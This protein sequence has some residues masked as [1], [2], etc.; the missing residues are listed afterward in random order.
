MVVMKQAGVLMPLASLPS[1][2]GVGDMGPA[3][4]A[5][6]D[7]LAQM[8]M[9]VWQVLP[10]NPLGYGN[11]PYQPYSSFAGD[12]IYLSPEL[13]LKDG[14][15]TATDL[16][17]LNASATRIDYPA[18]RAYKEQ[19]LHQAFIN[20]SRKS[21][22]NASLAEFKASTPWLAD[23]ALFMALKETNHMQPW[24][25]WPHEHKHALS[26]DAAALRT[27]LA[28]LI[29]YHEF[30]QF[31][32]FR[33]WQALKS[34]ANQHNIRIMGDIPIYLG[35]DS[36]DVWAN[37]ELF[38]LDPDGNPRVVAGVPPD[39]FSSTGQRWGN[40]IY[41]WKQLA[42]TGFEFW[43]KRLE[44]NQAAYDIIRIDHFRAFDTYWQIPSQCPTAIAGEWCTAPGY[45]LFDAIYAKLPDIQIVVE[46][47][48]DLRQEVLELRDHYHLAGM[49]IFQWHFNPKRENT[50][51]ATLANT[52]IYT[53]THDNST[54][55]GWYHSL[56]KRQRQRLHK[57]FG[58]QTE[59]VKAIVTYLVNCA[60]AYVIFP[61]QDLLGLDDSC[62]LNRPGT[63]GSPNWEW[64][65]TDFDHLTEQITWVADALTQ[66][67]RNSIT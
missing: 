51:F 11:S 15:L 37:Q 33:Q 45:Q 59:L 2:Y 16:A 10:L 53:G 42:K 17:P 9:R 38:L 49:Q 35:L 57:F 6:I 50:Q 13:L 40:P 41:N 56:A 36:A 14:L 52:I 64:R 19:L 48:G 22:F 23:Y 60:A 44:G 28:A 21:Q 54:L 43:L 63:I 46:D 18:A 30:V 34:Y 3:A 20:F 55:I 26:Y 5:L 7:I 31:M 65:L 29:A 24:S 25:V 39:Y 58:T 32:F 4:F 67:N 66:S 12:L 62:R 1:P 27:E 47:L 8:G 61:I